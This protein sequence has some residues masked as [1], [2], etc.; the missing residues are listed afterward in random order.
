[1]KK[2]LELPAF[3]RLAAA[4]ILNELAFLIAETALALLVYRRTGSALAATAF[5]LCAQFGP[6]FVSLLL[7]T[8]LDQGS[9]RLALVLLYALE[10]LI[11]FVLGEFVER[12][13]VGMVLL[14]ALA[15]GSL[16]ISARVLSRAAWTAVTTAA[17]VLR[18]ANAVVNSA[19]SVCWL[20]GPAVGGGLVAAAGTRLPLFVNVGVFALCTFAV[21]TATGLPRTVPDR[22]PLASR[23]RSAVIYA[24]RETFV[25]RLLSLQGAFMIFFTIS[26]P[27]EVVFARHTLHAGAGGYGLLL[28]AWGGAAIAGSVLYARWRR[29]STRLLIALGSALVGAGLLTMA[30]A[31]NLAVATAGA[32]IAGIGNGI[33]IVAMRTALQEAT[34]AR[35]MAVILGLNE[36][37]FQA[38]PGIGIVAGGALTALAGPRVAFG[39]GAA[40]TLAI[41]LAAWVALPV[42]DAETGSSV[43]AA[44]P[45]AP[46]E[47]LTTAGQRE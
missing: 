3:R 41:A 2:A 10:A 7:V 43:A 30:V 45:E 12:L 4:A 8:R 42:L 40:G 22:T 46:N 1:M 25:R 29:L 13:P 6:A 31:P 21:A 44:A 18:E 17:G 33:E 16:A 32:A 5:F 39:A 38:M 35:W 26:I 37:M 23:I 11:F 20:V 47:A 24:R 9:V 36:T 19:A 34:P 14:L 27:V 28:S 15:Q